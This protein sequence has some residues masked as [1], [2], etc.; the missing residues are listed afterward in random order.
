MRYDKADMIK[1]T[2]DMLV[3]KVVSLEPMH[4]LEVTR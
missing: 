3:L 4:P 2:L 1:G